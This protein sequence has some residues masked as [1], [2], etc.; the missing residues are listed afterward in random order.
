MSPYNA[1]S[2]TAGSQPAPPV[3]PAQ[4]FLGAVQGAMGSSNPAT[5]GAGVIAGGQSAGIAQ[6]GLSM[7]QLMQEIG[8]V[9][10]SAGLS[11]Q[12]GAQQLEQ[13]LSGIGIQ[14]G[15]NALSQQGAQ[16]Q[17][18]QTLAQQ[19]FT[20]QE[21]ALS[22]QQYPEQLAEA[23]QQNKEAVFN[24]SAQ[25]A[26]SGTL[27]TQGQAMANQNQSLQYGWQQQDINRN[28]GLAKLGQEAG[29]SATQYSL[30]DIARSEQNLSL[31]AA[32]NGL[33][34]EQ[35]KSQYANQ[36]GQ[37][38]TGAESDLTQL[39]T[40]Y[41]AQQGQQVG[42]VGAAGAQL[43]LLSPGQIT[44]QGQNAGLNLSSLFTGNLNG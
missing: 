30:G 21:Y 8:L 33:S 15:Q 5:Q 35:L 2:G 3:T 17:Y 36:V 44:A 28:A 6:S 34:V 40:Q 37:T 7:A 31:T 38:N 4:G 18:G 42:D 24:Q 10:Q 11:N 1:A 26:A 25:G 39:Y 14:Q 27:N 22:S 32:A 12:Y 23:A 13:G 9:D 20:N 19:G 16:A 41:L 43:G 29:Q